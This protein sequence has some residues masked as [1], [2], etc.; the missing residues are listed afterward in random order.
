MNISIHTNNS[1][2]VG[3]RNSLLQQLPGSVQQAGDWGRTG[4]SLNLPITCLCC[5]ASDPDPDGLSCS[6]FTSG[7]IRKSEKNLSTSPLPGTGTSIPCAQGCSD[8][9]AGKCS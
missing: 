7:C 5:P 8:G 6:P 9:T 1:S 4:F 2:L 3:E